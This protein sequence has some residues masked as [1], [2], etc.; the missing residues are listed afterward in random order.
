MPSVTSVWEGAGWLERA[1]AQLGTRQVGLD[2]T[3]SADAALGQA[4][5]G[6]HALPFCRTVVR[7]VDAHD[8][9]AFAQQVDQQPRVVRRLDPVGGGPYCWPL[10][11]L[12]TA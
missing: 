9:H 3:A 4:Q 7:A 5:I 2:A 10:R 8:V 12:Q 6:D 11:S 1:S